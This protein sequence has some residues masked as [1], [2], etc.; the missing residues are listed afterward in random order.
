M[1]AKEWV[2]VALMA[3]LVACSTQP[4]QKGA[5]GVTPIGVFVECSGDA[6]FWLTRDL[7]S[8]DSALFQVRTDEAMS[9]YT[10]ECVSQERNTIRGVIHARGRTID[11]FAY[12][13]GGGLRDTKLTVL[14]DRVSLSAATLTPSPIRVY[15][16]PV[17]FKDYGQ[18]MDSVV[19]TEFERDPCSKLF[20]IAHTDAGAN[21][22]IELIKLSHS[23]TGPDRMYSVTGRI[24]RDTAAVDVLIGVWLDPYATPLA[25]LTPE[26]LANARSIGF[27]A[28][29]GEFARNA[30][31][32][33]LRQMLTGEV[34]PRE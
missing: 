26:Q 13:I 34:E 7:L 25:R 17:G 14:C 24:R 8:K 4:P 33:I 5:D 11:T 10:L 29:T 32:K 9:D 20:E 18:D 23:E 1:V 30:K 16:S 3:A 22:V 19:V 27:T 6:R 2:V 12:S 31:L 15:V 28:G 21:Y